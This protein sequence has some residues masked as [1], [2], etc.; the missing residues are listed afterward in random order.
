MK[1]DIKQIIKSVIRI[2]KNS[3]ILRLLIFLIASVT[4]FYLISC[5]LESLVNFIYKVK[6]SKSSMNWN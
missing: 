5:I 6:K 3:Q 2:L 1:I 4:G